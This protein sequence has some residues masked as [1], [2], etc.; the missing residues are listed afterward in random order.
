MYCILPRDGG[1]ECTASSR[2]RG[3]DSLFY[4]H[5]MKEIPIFKLS[6]IIS[7]YYYPEHIIGGFAAYG[8]CERSELFSCSAMS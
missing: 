1:G 5:K 2:A 7:P 3:E 4:P 8:H 6:S